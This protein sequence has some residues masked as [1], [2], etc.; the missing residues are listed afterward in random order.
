[1]KHYSSPIFFKERPSD[2]LQDN[3]L[4]ISDQMLPWQLPVEKAGIE[5]DC[6]V[7]AGDGTFPQQAKIE[8]WSW[9]ILGQLCHHPHCSTLC[10]WQRLPQE[11]RENTISGRGTY[12]FKLPQLWTGDEI[13]AMS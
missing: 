5:G 12:E 9:L 13:K 1:M 11:K 2:V 6:T 8:N 3:S 4:K 7:T 10:P